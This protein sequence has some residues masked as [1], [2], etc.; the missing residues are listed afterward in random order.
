[1]LESCDDTF[2]KE[3]KKKKNTALFKSQTIAASDVNITINNV[4]GMH[5]TMRH[6]HQPCGHL[7]VG[8][9]LGIHLLFLKREPNLTVVLFSFLTNI[10]L[11]RTPLPLFHLLA[12]LTLAP[13]SLEGFTT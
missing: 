11:N 9:I 4:H 10:N 2:R 1:M 7:V 3:R 8:S 12:L 6:Q 13:D 5:G